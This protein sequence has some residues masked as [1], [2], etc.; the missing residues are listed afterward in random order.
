VLK[1][2][3]LTAGGRSKVVFEDEIAALQEKA[4]RAR[5]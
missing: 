2:F 4:A 3:N 5:R 1:P